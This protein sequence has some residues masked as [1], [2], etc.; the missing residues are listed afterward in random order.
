[1]L[2]ETGEPTERTETTRVRFLNDVLAVP[3][4]DYIEAALMNALAG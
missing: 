2:F 3:D 1:M 4:L